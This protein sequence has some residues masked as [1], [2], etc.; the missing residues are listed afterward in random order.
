MDYERR[1]A[2]HRGTPVLEPLLSTRNDDEAVL[3]RG[4]TS[5][6]L[7]TNFEKEELEAHRTVYIGL[8]VPSGRR[9]HRR[10]RHR[11]GHRH[12]HRRRVRDKE[13]NADDSESGCQD[14]PSQRVQ[15]ILGVEDDDE[16]H[17]AHDLF[18]EMDELCMRDGEECEWRETARWLKFEEDVEDGGERWSKPYV[19]TLSLHSLFELRSCIMNGT[20]MLDMKATTLDEI[21]DLVLDNQIASGQLDVAVRD[22]VRQALLKRHHHQS[23]KKLSHRIPIVRSLADMG[24]KY[25]DTHLLEKNGFLTSPHSAPGNLADEDKV[26]EG[27]AGESSTVDFSKVDLNFLRKIPQGAEASNVL[28]GEV[29]FLERPVIAF[30]RLSPAVLLSGLAEVPIPTRFLFILLGPAGKATQYHEIG[31]SIATLMSDE[32]FSDVAYKA[33]DRKDLLSGIDEFLDQ[34]TVLPP[35]EWDPSIRIEPPKNV[36]SQEKRKLPSL[37]NGA[38]QALEPEHESHGAGP[39]LQRTGRIFGGLV[40]D[41]KRKIPFYWSDYRDSLNLQCIASF[42]FLYCACMSPVITFGGLL[43]EATEGRISAIE[44]LFGASMT[45]IAYSLFAGQPLTI[46][47]STGPVLVFEKILY[48]FCKD[49]YLSYLSL[50]ACIGLW[51]AFFCLLLV[52]TDA[53]SLVCYI[54]RFTEEAFASLICIIFIYEAL[55]K[56]VHLGETYEVNMHADPELLTQYSCVCVEPSVPSNDTLDAWDS[57]N[58]T[59]DSI[60]WGNLT[61]S[62]CLEL[63][64]EFVGTACGHHGPYIPD[65]LFWS[66]I[67]FFATFFLSGFL[68]QFKTMRYFPTKVR[69][70]VSDFAVFLTILSMVVIDY[71]LGIPSPKLQVPSEFKPTRDDRGWIVDPIGRNP[72]WTILAAAIPA[73]L[74]TILVFMDQ[75]ITA[76]IINRKEHKLKKGCGYH[77]D[78][79]WVA[80]MLAVCSIMGLPWFVAATVLS[81]SHVNSLKVESECSAPGEQPKFLGI[82]EQRVT[83][84]MIFVLMG[85]SVFMTGVLKFIPMPVLYGVFLYMGASSLKGIQFFDRIKLFGMPAKHQPDFIYLRHVPLRKVHLFTAVQFTCLVLLWVI[86]ASPAA[87]V[88]PMM[89]L[90]LVFIRKLLDFC[91]TKRELSWLDDLMPESRK[92]KL[93]DALR[94]QEDSEETQRMLEV[95]E[96]GTVQVPLEGGN[97]LKIPV[98]GIKFSQRDP[99]IINISEEMSKTAVWKTLAGN[100][101][102]THV[103]VESAGQ[104]P[105]K[106]VNLVPGCVEHHAPSETSV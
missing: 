81:I 86:K 35:G 101:D 23:E 56:L 78:L 59:A 106:K 68:K 89:V 82:R 57:M 102:N 20:V 65:V 97:V 52:A 79:L 105:G 30:V 69:S 51:T 66:I 18:T 83:G 50:R 1:D 14:T 13:A 7:L 42:L 87:I 61:V 74:C 75:Q 60:P 80:I 47:G 103:D 93:E 39:E 64:G 27:R 43:G 46:L 16:E 62:K 90:A 21:A 26:C 49:Y 9:S 67:L 94:E 31:R 29:D 63:H 96:V 72:W 44:S 12:H 11:G 92:K 95:A 25:S 55:E 58:H 76:V 41:I 38:S 32:I 19:A 22:R 3:D 54:T 33:K 91:F 24:K 5:A 4:K 8:H 98:K 15:F 2:Q 53:S 104:N 70:T 36:P 71:F 48:K 40:R 73:L 77:L 6:I 34:V 84:L 99:S 85:C 28:V 37:V 88:F 100:T 17:V 45:G 10:H